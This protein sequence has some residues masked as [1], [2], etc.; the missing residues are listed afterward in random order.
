MVRWVND[1]LA[2]LSYIY[3]HLT[4]F[5][6]KYL[7]TR[8]KEMTLKEVYSL[9]EGLFKKEMNELEKRSSRYTIILKLVAQGINTWTMLKN[10]FLAKGD[11]ISDSRLFELLTTLEKMSLI[12][13]TQSGY[14]ILDPVFERI[15]KGQST[16]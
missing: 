14:R 7:E 5:G 15:L 11:M 3:D 10:H 4:K 8:D 9:M 13:K 16:L 2:F 6:L 1:L 12:E